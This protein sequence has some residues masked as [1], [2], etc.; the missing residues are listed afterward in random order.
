MAL[1]ARP[2]V[3]LPRYARDGLEGS[4]AQRGSMKLVADVE[5][6][7]RI[8]ARRQAA[9]RRAGRPKSR[10]GAAPGCGDPALQAL[11]NRPRMSILLC[12]LL[13]STP[14]SRNGPAG[15]FVNAFAK[16]RAEV[17]ASSRAS[18]LCF[19]NSVNGLVLSSPAAALASP[20]LSPSCFSSARILFRSGPR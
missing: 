20:S 13:S 5:P 14:A 16:S 3:D 18:S 19:S 1:P 15:V 8:R 4:V 11:G 10:R 6:D 9:F 12:P 17:K 2:A 7:L